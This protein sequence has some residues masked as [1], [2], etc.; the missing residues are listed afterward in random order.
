MVGEQKGGT[1]VTVSVIDKG[2]QKVVVDG[3]NIVDGHVVF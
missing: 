1:G 3:M 2:V